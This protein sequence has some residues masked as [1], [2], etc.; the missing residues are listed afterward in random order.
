MERASAPPR[1]APHAW[2][3]CCVP[4]A[5]TRRRRRARST[6]TSPEDR[7]LPHV[8]A[9]S[10]TDPHRDRAWSPRSPWRGCGTDPPGRRRHR[11][12]YG[13]RVVLAAV[14]CPA[15]GGRLAEQHPHPRPGDADPER[16]GRREEREGEHPVAVKAA[17]G[18]VGTV[19]LSYKYTTARARPKGTVDG[20]VSK[21]KTGWTAGERLEP[22]ATY[23]LSDDRQESRGHR[24]H[25]EVHLQDPVADPAASRPSPS[26]SRSRAARSASGCPSS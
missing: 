20:T 17:N 5:S 4:P 11:A 2:H 6:A 22:S 8:P 7:Y 25:A 16:R 13:H 26:S 15:L 3:I 21:D 14:G 24:D 23:K 1:L 10:T 9:R 19:K 12:R 18:T